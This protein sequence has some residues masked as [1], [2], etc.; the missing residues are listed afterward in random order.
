MQEGDR[1]SFPCPLGHRLT[2]LA[3]GYSVL[4]DSGPQTPWSQD[5][6]FP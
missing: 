6:L 2:G 3:N 5:T 1:R 4:G